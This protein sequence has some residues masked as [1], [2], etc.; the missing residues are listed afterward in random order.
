VRVSPQSVTRV[1][2]YDLETQFRFVFV[3]CV[4][5]SFVVPL[6]TLTHAEC[7]DVKRSCLRT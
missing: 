3:F 6:A 1:P 7:P 4:A 5:M 2:F